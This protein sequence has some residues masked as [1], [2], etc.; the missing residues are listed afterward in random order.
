MVVEWQVAKS[1]R[2]CAH[3]GRVLEEGEV[4]Y[5][6]LVEDG[7][8]FVREDYA[9]EAWPDVD[10]GRFF[11]YWRTRVPDAGEPRRRLVIDVEAFYSFFASLEDPQE[12]HRQ[13]FRYLVSLILTRKRVLRLD[14]IEKGPEGDHLVLYD[15]RAEQTVRVFCPPVTDEQLAQAQENLNEI[16]ECQIDPAE[17]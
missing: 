4:H 3:T 16:F 15:R 6:A 12:P 8:G 14:E 9:G 7:E 5:S 11:G 13:V 17:S 1:S 2:V 10:K